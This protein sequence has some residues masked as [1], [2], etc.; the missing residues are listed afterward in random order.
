LSH[1]RVEPPFSPA[2]P[3]VAAC[4]IEPPPATRPTLFVVVDTEEEF[5]WTSGFFSRENTRVEAIRQL[6]VLQR[7]L[8]RH[9]VKPTYVID[10][11]V[12]TGPSSSAVIRALAESGSCAVGAHLHPWVNPPYTEELTRANSF[13]SNLGAATELA[14]LTALTEAIEAHVGVRPRIYKAGRYGFGPSTVRSLEQLGYTIDVSVNP[15]MDFSAE[16]GPNFERFDSR[17]F[18]FGTNHRL[19]EVPCTHGFAGFLRR[20][21]VSLHRLSD[22][23][24]GRAVRLPGVLARAG[25]LNKIMLSPENSTFAEMRDLTVA[26]LADGIRTFSFT[27]HSPSIEEGH[28]P[29][30]RTTSDLRT[31]LDRIDAFCDFFFGS[32][33]GVSGTLDEFRQ[34]NVAGGNTA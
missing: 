7:L 13:A 14:K 9:R 10:Y 27:L 25:A 34:M 6:P 30:V 16:Q 21:G 24:P 23:R 1:T 17:P 2:H 32:L 18:W 8:D 3:S 26:L 12:A 31:F 20:R 15:L 22:T 11:P 4:P 28:T 33:G 5:D 29:Y 19:L